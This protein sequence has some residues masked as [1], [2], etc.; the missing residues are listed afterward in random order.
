M[1]DW[2]VYAVVLDAVG[3]DEEDGRGGDCGGCA[4]VRVWQAALCCRG[5]AG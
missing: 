4:G 5:A 3:C 2:G 1:I